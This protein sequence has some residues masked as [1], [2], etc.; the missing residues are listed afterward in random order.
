MTFEPTTIVRP[1]QTVVLASHEPRGTHLLLQGAERRSAQAFALRRSGETALLHCLIRLV[2]D[3]D[4]TTWLVRRADSGRPTV[5]HPG[6]SAPVHISIA[7]TSGLAVAAAST[8]G[9]IGI[10]IESLQRR[11]DVDAFADTYFHDDEKELLAALPPDE[12]SDAF[13]R[14]WTLKE[15]YG[16]TTGNGLITT[17][18]TNMDRVMIE[19]LHDD[20]T[21][22]LSFYSGVVAGRYR[23]AVAVT[24]QSS[25][26]L[27]LDDSQLERVLTL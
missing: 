22:S 9:P 11:V 20:A 27:R 17:A 6:V 23:V 7:H 5:R 13:F 12:L 1:T 15:A 4:P 10:D 8:S 21:R 3:V 26:F 14:L 25:S 24:A 18:E 16:K 2:P 19:Q